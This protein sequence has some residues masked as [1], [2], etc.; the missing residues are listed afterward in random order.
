MRT[1]AAR[2]LN[3]FTVDTSRRPS[4]ASF[5]WDG[6]NRPTVSVPALPCPALPSTIARV[7]L[8]YPTAWRPARLRL[9][10][11]DPPGPHQQLLLENTERQHEHQH[12]HVHKHGY[13]PCG[14]SPAPSGASAPTCEHARRDVSRARPAASKKVSSEERGV[15]SEVWDCT[16]HRQRAQLLITHHGLA[17]T[18][19]AHCVSTPWATGACLFD[20]PARVSPSGLDT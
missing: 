2:T 1:S 8:T 9:E 15:R 7:K 10:R 18:L 3:L 20:V 12:K 13:R 17:L 4:T 16:R 11:R 19:T 6:G 5:R 14:P